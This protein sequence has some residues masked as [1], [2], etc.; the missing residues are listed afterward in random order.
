MTKTFLKPKLSLYLFLSVKDPYY[1]YE[2]TFG[3]SVVIFGFMHLPIQ[4]ESINAA[5]N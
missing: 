5:Q 4:E 1:L 3:N 2:E